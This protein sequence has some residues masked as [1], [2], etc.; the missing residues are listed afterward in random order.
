[1]ELSDQE[2]RLRDTDRPPRIIIGTPKRLLQIVQANASLFQKTK[3]I[4][5]DEVDKALQPLHRRA[6]MKK[7]FSRASHPRPSKELVDKLRKASKVS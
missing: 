4:V 7:I 6:S 5:I 1:M 2:Q 3:R